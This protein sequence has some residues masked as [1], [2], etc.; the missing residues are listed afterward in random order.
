MD[1]DGDLDAF[2]A[3][4]MAPDQIWVNDG[5]GLFSSPS[6]IMGSGGAGRSAAL[7]DL[8]GDGDLD[9][10]VA[11]DGEP[12]IVSLNKDC[13]VVMATELLNA[14]TALSVNG[15]VTAVFNQPVD[16]ATIGMSTFT[17]RGQ[18]FGV[19]PGTYT[20][21]SSNIVEFHSMADFLFGES[22]HVTLSSNV[23][24]VNGLRLKPHGFQ[25]EVESKGCEIAT[26]VN[27][28]SEV[29]IL[30]KGVTM[31]DLNGDGVP[32]AYVACDT[33]GD[34]VFFNTGTGAFVDSGQ[35]LGSFEA[36]V[37]STMETWTLLSQTRN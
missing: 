19:Y 36:S 23:M 32:D 14:E 5:A 8:D 16:P 9:A 12:N 3:N 37:D 20:L 22:I 13:F 15:L 7:G 29:A 28:G 1:G 2:V 24:S 34:R 11:N 35:R 25:C 21:P 6:P 26:Y 30:P 33:D 10:W 17:V 18:Q 4:D 27:S 31:S